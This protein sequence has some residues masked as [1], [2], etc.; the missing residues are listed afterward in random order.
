MLPGTIFAAEISIQLSHDS[1]APRSEFIASVYIDT[2]GEDLN[3]YEGG[4]RYPQD[5]LELIGVRDGSSIAT[6]WLAPP[7]LRD[8]DVVF[9]GITPGG[10][11]GENGFLFSLVF[12]ARQTGAGTIG[13]EDILVLKNDGEGTQAASRRKDARVVVSRGAPPS[14]VDAVD[15]DPPEPF[16]A[17]ISTA[18]DFFDGAPFVSFLAHDKQTGV[19]RYEWAS[20]FFFEPSE[21]A[22]KETESPLV[23]SKAEQYKMIFIRAIDSGGNARVITIAGPK[24]TLVLILFLIIALCV[25]AVVRMSVRRFLRR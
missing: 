14:S 9:S 3:A 17:V 18:P 25:L 13:V 20:S 22:W 16:E 11:R 8:G 10:Y 21:E 6:I 5:L 12:R 4:V 1:V 19:A 23:L 2:E 7:A 15:T 24:H